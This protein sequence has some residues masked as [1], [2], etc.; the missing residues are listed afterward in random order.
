VRVDRR[1]RDVGVAQ[2][3]LDD[4]QVGAVVQEV[5]REGVAQHVRRKRARR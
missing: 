1:R 5:R 4:A 3:E 2:Q